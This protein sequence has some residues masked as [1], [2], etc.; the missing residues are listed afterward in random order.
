MKL[1]KIKYS[2]KKNQN[3]TRNIKLLLLIIVMVFVIVPNVSFNNNSFIYG[4]HP[5]SKD[6]QS[7]SDNAVGSGTTPSTSKHHSSKDT[8]SGSD[9]AVGSGTT[10]STSKHHSSKDT[11]SGSDNA[12][13]SGTTPSTGSDNAVGS[14]T[15]PS[16][17]KH[18][19]SKDTQSSSDNAVG[20]GTTPS[21]GSHNSSKDTQSS[22]G[23]TPSTTQAPA[24]ITHLKILKV[25]KV[26]LQAPLQAPAVIT[27]L[28]ILKVAK[29][30][31]PP[32]TGNGTNPST[33]NLPSKSQIPSFSGSCNNYN[34]Q[35][36]VNSGNN[37]AGQQGSKNGANQNIKQSQSNT[38]NAC[39]ITKI[40][41][42]VIKNYIHSSPIV[43][44]QI[45]QSPNGLIQ[46]ILNRCVDKLE[47][48]L[49]YLPIVIS[50]Y[51]LSKQQK[52]ILAIGF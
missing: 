24:V 2:N 51:Y 18:H 20:S 26:S 33:N 4:K 17:S 23:I 49:V 31:S 36:Q 14:G 25:A 13:G 34:F 30:F 38:Q 28:K 46:L 52:I 12:V 1:I 21:T 7:G 43:Q 39:T 48:R 27:H 45:L 22:K 9:N 42:Q 3:K 6:T 35:T 29:V 37:T 40:E 8:Q 16:T 11:Q 10:P 41:N 5:S 15:T 32:S 19:S 44:K 50:K 47:I